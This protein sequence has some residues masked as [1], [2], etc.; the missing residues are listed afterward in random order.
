M[1][2]CLLSEDAVEL[3]VY[4]LLFDVAEL[5]A[6]GARK[7][8]I[9]SQRQMNINHVNTMFLTT[10]KNI[11]ETQ[12]RATWSSI[13]QEV[14]IQKKENAYSECRT[15]VDELWATHEDYSTQ[16]DDIKRLMLQCAH[17]A[18]LCASA[19]HCW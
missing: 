19:D 13:Y 16:P 14:F 1:F 4:R 10:I 18:R 5:S 6:R 2:T 12:M 15:W 11:W 7:G 8:L 3:E 9:E 17:W